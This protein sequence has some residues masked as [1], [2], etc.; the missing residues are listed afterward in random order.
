MAGVLEL[1]EELGREIMGWLVADQ[2]A[3]FS[4][5]DTSTTFCSSLVSYL[6]EHN[7]PLLIT[8]AAE[9]GAFELLERAVAQYPEA[10]INGSSTMKLS[11]IC[12]PYA[13]VI[14]AR[15]GYAKVVELILTQETT[16]KAKDALIEA[17]KGGHADVVSVMLENFLGHRSSG[18]HDAL[19]EA[20]ERGHLE[21]KKVLREFSN[22]ACHYC[23]KNLNLTARNG[24]RGE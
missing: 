14:A 3:L 1:R 24:K 8:W 20:M 22:P 7:P 4:L 10:T 16:H 11:D 5:Y 2:D 17:A 23:T 12:P 15:K 13:L 19:S 18:F 9:T 21:V 6:V